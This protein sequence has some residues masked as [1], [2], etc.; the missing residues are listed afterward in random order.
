ME[1]IYM[2]YMIIPGGDGDWPELDDDEDSVDWVPPHKLVAGSRRAASLSLNGVV[3]TT[4]KVQDAVWK[5][6][7]S[8]CGSRTEK[9]TD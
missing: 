3:V 4:L 7:I 5:Q 9:W 6:T 8:W 2:K 1:Y